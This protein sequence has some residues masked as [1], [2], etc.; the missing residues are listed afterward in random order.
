M[1]DWTIPIKLVSPNVMEHW[2]VKHQ[3][4]KMI[5]CVLKAKW[6]SEDIKIEPPCIVTLTRQASRLF[7]EDNLVF[8]FKSIRDSLSSL[9][10]PGYAPGQADGKASGITW[11][12]Q[13]EKVPKV[14]QV[15]IQIQS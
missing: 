1:I 2:R 13:Q 10:R 7:D 15:R 14:N 6:K 8:A 9:L 5:A 11:V 4:N 3:R 12:Y